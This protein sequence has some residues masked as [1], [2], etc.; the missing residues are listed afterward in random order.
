MCDG[1]DY[2][3]FGLSHMGAY[4]ATPTSADGFQYGDDIE[5]RAWCARNLFEI[6]LLCEYVMTDPA[7]AKEF[8]SQKA[9]DELQ[10]NEGFVSLADDPGHPSLHIVADRNA[11]IRQVMA[12]HGMAESKPLMVAALAKRTGNQDEYEAFLQTLFEICSS[13]A[14]LIFAKQNETDTPTLRN[15]FVIQAQFYAAENSE[16][17]SG[18][19]HC[20]ESGTSCLKE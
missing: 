20:I 14:W 9:S 16:T 2:L 1:T 7:R 10:I 18:F 19:H 4:A 5:I 15:V 8:V 6:A 17:A 13:S 11:Q 3:G 12:K